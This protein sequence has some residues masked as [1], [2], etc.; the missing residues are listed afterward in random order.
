MIGIS[1]M[2]EQGLRDPLLV[3]M[4]RQR[5]QDT[6]ALWAKKHPERDAAMQKWD[7]MVDDRDGP[8]NPNRV[9]VE[10]EKAMAEEI[11][12][13]GAA[14]GAAQVG[15]TS[16]K[17]EYIEYGV[18]IPHKNV[19][20]TIHYEDYRKAMDGPDAVDLEAMTTYV[21]CAVSSTEIA[22]YIREELGYPAV[23][24]HNGAVQIQAIPVMHE[25]GMG[26]LG[27]HGSLINPELGANFRP[28]IITTDLPVAYDN[29]ISFGVQDYCMTC[30]LCT[31]NCPG[32]AIPE[33][34]NDHIITNG[35]RRWLTDIEKC[36][37]IS[38][39]REEYCHVCV[40]VCPFIHKMNDIEGRKDTYKAYMK[41]RKAEGYKTPKTNKPKP[42]G[43]DA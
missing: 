30:N 2:R 11:K 14:L 33:D 7:D 40:D 6:I 12:R 32:D 41:E 16:L 39:F 23:A 29:P 21:D 22:R 17:P 13:R 1:W 27:K 5:N 43:A 8:V 31:N 10:D 3:E 36:Y 19:I 37:P 25:V 38:R 42:A 18:E 28:G 34:S 15:M 24:H 9:A 20:V 26:E 4:L 35:Q